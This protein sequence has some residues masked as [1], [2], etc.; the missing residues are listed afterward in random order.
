MPLLADGDQQS[1]VLL[2]CGHITPHLSWLMVTSSPWCPL[3]VAPS[4]QSPFV[5]YVSSSMYPGFAA[6]FFGCPES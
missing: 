2:G 1:L 6:F 5:V 3:A 4:P